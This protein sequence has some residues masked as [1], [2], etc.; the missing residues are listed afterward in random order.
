MGAATA[1]TLV[2]TAASAQAYGGHSRNYG[3]DARHGDRRHDH[4]GGRA[5][6][7]APSVAPAPYGRSGAVAAEN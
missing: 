5:Y 4:Y 2:S 6:R 7:P 1:M 3:Y